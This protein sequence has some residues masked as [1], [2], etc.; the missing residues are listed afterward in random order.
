MGGAWFWI[1][2]RRPTFC[3][4]MHELHPA[5][6]TTGPANQFQ[7]PFPATG[8]FFRHLHVSSVWLGALGVLAVKKHIFPDTTPHPTAWPIYGQS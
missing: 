8:S 5:F 2:T 7:Q 4:Q 6:S 3:P 1:S